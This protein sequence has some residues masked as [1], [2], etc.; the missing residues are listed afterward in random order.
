VKV[1]ALSISVAPSN[2]FTQPPEKTDQFPAIKYELRR[3][4]A[5]SSQ[6]LQAKGNEK[7]SAERVGI[8]IAH[9]RLTEPIDT[10]MDNLAIVTTL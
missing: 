4:G 9:R 3:F 6:Y 1:V 10:R 7:R 2:F 5:K 8:C